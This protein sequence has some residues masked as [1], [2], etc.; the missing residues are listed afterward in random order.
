MSNSYQS[1]LV[2][3][4]HRLVEYITSRQIDKLGPINIALIL[5]ENQFLPPFSVL[6]FHTYSGS[7]PLSLLSVF[8]MLL[9][10]NGLNLAGKFIQT[11]HT[12]V[13]L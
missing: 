2:L 6:Y 9:K 11:M 3:F 13:L 4:S 8:F 7:M 12:W 5:I 1:P 10:L